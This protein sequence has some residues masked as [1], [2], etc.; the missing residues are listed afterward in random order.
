MTQPA[1]LEADTETVI[2]ETS[3]RIVKDSTIKDIALIELGSESQDPSCQRSQKLA[4]NSSE[5][6]SGLIPGTEM[7]LLS[8][9]NIV[10]KNSDETFEETEQRD[11]VAESEETRP[12]SVW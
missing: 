9:G 10:V 8:M 11:S 6:S 3:S 7:S 12:A 1:G 5:A 2:H 4:E